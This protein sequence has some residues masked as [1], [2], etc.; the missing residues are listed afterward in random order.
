MNI[1]QVKNYSEMSAKAADMLISKLHEKPNMNLGLAT[2]GTPK[3]LYDHLIQDHKE[4][5]T[6]YKH[7]TSFNLDE[8]VGMKPQDPNSYHYYMADAL[9][10][11]IDIDVSN[12]HVPNG[13]A[14]TPEEE[15]RRYDEMIQNHG[16]IDLQILGIGQNGHIGFNEPGTSFNS[17]THIVTLEESTRKAN[18]RY[19]NSLDEVPTQAITMGIE[20]I[21]KSKEILLLISGEAKAEAMYQLLNGEITENFPASI[22]KKHHCVTIIADQEALA[23]VNL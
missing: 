10:N 19:F 17:P 18:A 1:I 4:H 2:G 8:Y 20:S 21:M 9:F 5:G 23:K 3:G 15:C 7:V 11:H 16:G 13:L 22:L 14:D 6:S 12:T